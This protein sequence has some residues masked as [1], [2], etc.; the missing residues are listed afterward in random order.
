MAI[1][2]A[3][4]A[5]LNGTCRVNGCNVLFS[6]RKVFVLGPFC[7]CKIIIESDMV[8]VVNY[9]PRLLTSGMTSVVRKL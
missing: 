9:L 3:S 1:A 7:I 2:A 5:I 6:L 4:T 8:E